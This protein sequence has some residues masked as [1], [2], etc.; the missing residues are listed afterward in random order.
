MQKE[1][2]NQKGE[3]ASIMKITKRNGLITV[4]DDEKIVNSILKASNDA[5]GEQISKAIAEN[6]AG[7]VFTRLTAENDIIT[8]ADVRTCVCQVLTERGYT[9]TAKAYSEFRK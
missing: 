1:L 5:K 7:D 4:F 6:I 2:G 9:G 8:T 3:E